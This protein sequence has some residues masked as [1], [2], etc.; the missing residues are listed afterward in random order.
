MGKRV[1]VVGYGKSASDAALEAA[2][3][4]NE[5]HLVFRETHWPVPRNLAGILPFKWGMLSRMTGAMITPYAHPS[6]VA[7]W[8]HSLGKPLVWIFWRLVELLLYVQ[9]GLG[10]KI[11]K[12]R[13]LVP[14]TPVHIDCFGESTMVPRSEL[15][16]SIRSGCVMAHRTEIAAFTRD[17]VELKDGETLA[18]NCVVFGTGWSCDYSF[19]SDEARRILGGADDGFYLYRHMVHPDLPNLFFIGRASTFINIL[20]YCLQARWLTELID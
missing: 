3:V 7:R 6:P 11:T 2:A 20:T 16:K 10:T 13:N 15:Y 12:G 19:L 4:A 14:S 18:L 9:W 1:A 17:G 5:V 8:L